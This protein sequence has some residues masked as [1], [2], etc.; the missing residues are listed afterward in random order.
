MTDSGVDS[1]VSPSSPDSVSESHSPQESIEMLDTKPPTEATKTALE[2]YKEVPAQITHSTE[3]LVAKMEVDD[4]CMEEKFIISDEK[5]AD[6]METVEALLSLSDASRSPGSSPEKTLITI[7]PAHNPDKECVVCGRC[8]QA[9]VSL[10]PHT[11][12]PHYV[13]L[14]NQP[15]QPAVSISFGS[16]GQVNCGVCSKQFANVYRLQRH[17]ISHDES[18]ILRRFKCTDCGKAFKFKHHLKEHIRIHTGDKPFECGFCH[19]RFSHSGSYSSHMTSKKC[20][21]AKLGSEEANINLQSPQDIKPIIKPEFTQTPPISFANKLSNHH[22]DHDEDFKEDFQEEDQSDGCHSPCPPPSQPHIQSLLFPPA[23]GLNPYVLSSSIANMNQLIQKTDPEQA[24]NANI[25]DKLNLSTL[26]PGMQRGTNEETRRPGMTEALFSNLGKLNGS[27]MPGQEADNLRLLLES[28]NIAVTRRL[29]ED[30]L[31]R[32]SGLIPQNNLLPSWPIPERLSNTRH[33]SYDSD[34]NFSD[35]E[36]SYQDQDISERLENSGFEKKSRVRS[37]ISE[38][39]LSVLKS[40]YNVNQMPRREELMQIADAI[41]HPYKVVKVWFQNSR[42]RDRREGKLPPL[43]ASQQASMSPLTPSLVKYPTPPP[44]TA[45]SQQQ[46][47]PAVSP[48]PVMVKREKELP[49]DLTTKHLSPSVTPPPLI[50]ALSEPEEKPM[51]DFIQANQNGEKM[52]KENFEQMIREKLVSLEPDMEVAK[53]QGKRQEDQDEVTGVFNCDQCDKTFTKKSSIT[54]HK[55]EHSD[56]RPHKCTECEKAFKHKHHLT[57]HKR[58]HSGEKP[59]QCPKCHKRFSHSGSYSQHIN[60]R[61]SYCKP[62][63]PTNGTALPSAV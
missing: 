51:D 28:V 58:L 55:Y 54:R 6:K 47:S 11:C 41:G 53:S 42:A 49:L 57:E 62:A 33:N 50:V 44:S 45:S 14:P 23:T 17:M 20:Q 25:M 29:L 43:S 38:E 3:E 35:D 60:H 61:F 46:L 37:L 16:E 40:C 59:F 27:A 4:E 36:S 39:Q 30:N 63:V 31:L 56:L 19:K 10:E 18:S 9:L 1:E 7:I 22:E 24:A 34:G 32:W 13:S 21:G 12:P 5:I 8:G 26:F 52:S 48:V 2:Y 15:P